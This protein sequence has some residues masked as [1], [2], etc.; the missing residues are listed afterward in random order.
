MATAGS[1]TK[2]S[3][4]MDVEVSTSGGDGVRT[5]ANEIRK[6]GQ[7]GS[8]AG[9]E[10][11]RLASE[12]DAVAA[13]ADSIKAI[14]NLDAELRKAA[15]AAVETAAATEKMN[16]AFQEASSKTLAASEKYA[17]LVAQQSKLRDEN[18]A[19][20]LTLADLKLNT[21]AVVA[22]TSAHQEVVR[23]GKNSINENKKALL[24]LSSTLAESKAELNAAEAAE[25]RLADGL[26]KA[27]KASDAANAALRDRTA[28]LEG[29]QA[30]AGALGVQTDNL[31]VA[32]ERLTA[33]TK[34]LAASAEAQRAA[35]EATAAR[36]A[37]SA[38]IQAKFAEAVK[39]ADKAL[40]D[41]VATLRN[42]DSALAS[43]VA[44]NTEAIS[45]GEKDV[46]LNERR[47]AAARRLL[48][49][50]RLLSAAQRELANSM[51]TARA[52]TVAEAQAQVEAAA[53]AKASL[54]ATQALVT[55][56]RNAGA[57]IQQAFGVIGVRSLNEI[58]TELDQTET[59]LSLL[60]RR[61]KAGAISAGDLERAMGGAKVRMAQLQAEIANVPATPGVFERMS[62]TINHL[63][64]RFGALSAAIATVGI[65]VKPI[66]D[67]EI[68]LQRLN[69][70]LNTVTGS[71]EAT[72]QTIEFL[73]DVSQ[74]S[75]QSFSDLTGSFSKFAASAVNAGVPLSTVQTVFANA[76]RAAGNLGLETEATGRILNALGQIASKGTVQMEELKG[77]L[78]ESLPGAMNL[79]AK[80]LGL[81]TQE[82]TKLIESGGLLA[83]DAL[84]AIGDAMLQLASK[85]GE[86][87]GL[88]A[89][90]N[91]FT[92]VIKEAG[93]TVAEGAFGKAVGDILGGLG[94]SI[95]YVIFGVT[96]IAE[97]FTTTGQKIG[98]VIGALVTRDFKSLSGALDD[99]QKKSDE[100]MAGLAERITG[101]GLA[102]TAAAPKVQQLAS[103]VEASH[104]AVIA[105]SDSFQL[106]TQALVT[107]EKAHG[108]L[109]AANAG[110]VTALD[111]TATSVGA[112]ATL[113]P[114][115]VID[116]QK[117]VDAAVLNTQVTDKLAQAKKFEG[118]ALIAVAALAGN[119]IA[120]Q[121]ARAKAAQDAAAAARDQATADKELVATYEAK[122]VA[123]TK[124]AEAEGGMTEQ[125]KQAIEAIDKLIAKS[126]SEAEKTN[127][128][129]TSLEREAL[130][131]RLATEALDD[132]SSKLGEYQ[133]ALKEAKNAYVALEVEQ[134]RG[135][136]TSDQVAKAAVAVATAEA[137]VKDALDDT[138]AARARAVKAT[139]DHNNIILATLNLQK[140]QLQAEIAMYEAEGNSYKA[141]EA[142]IRL[143]ELEV[144]ILQATIDAKI[145][146]IKA[147]RLQ[148]EADVEAAKA[149][150]TY[151]EAKRAEIEARLAAIKVKELEAEAL[152]SGIGLMQ[153]QIDNLRMY[154]TESVK[155][156]GASA[157]AIGGE[158][159]AINKNTTAWDSN[160]A[161]LVKSA[162]ARKSTS[163][164]ATYDKNGWATNSDG[165]II[166]ARA[167]TPDSVLSS[168]QSAGFSAADAQTIAAQAGLI[169]NGQVVL[170]GE[171][172]GMTLDG[173]IAKAIAKQQAAQ[174]FAGVTN[175]D[176]KIRDFGST[177][178][179]E[180]GGSMVVTPGK[181][182]GGSGSSPFPSPSPAP[183][184]VSPTPA[185]AAVP[186]SV[187]RVIIQNPDG[188]T[189]QVDTASENDAAGLVMML[190][191]LGNAARRS[192]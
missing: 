30:S 5:L 147:T 28:A 190:K 139:Q 149:T 27:A 175:T 116:Y 43:Y 17:A 184:P 121:Q 177:I 37:E 79:T 15:T 6:L 173:A 24:E 54:A 84:P 40:E 64:N 34:D 150:G 125:R 140:A 112:Q 130:S 186:I 9:A 35:M 23:S 29:A 174:S 165:Q 2:R 168:I 154:G 162:D 66:I 70:V 143:K 182:A 185:P 56:A 96:L 159:T 7:D 129:A 153:K 31:V 39:I 65:A 134:R 59:A 145:A 61:F 138:A 51:N 19:T 157:T 48:E 104:T 179:T 180:S 113:W 57:A 25:K 167:N 172:A 114:R 161:A 78:G 103:A 81:T 33:S 107:S 90:W 181:T 111:K 41:Q 1:N 136:A 166:S 98:A 152:R 178:R 92:N 85:S 87:D 100:K 151:T 94:K 123:L 163:N 80:A 89:S 45:T 135:I 131:R 137:R 101:T 122:K 44:A 50:D 148:I 73:R 82:L 142:K 170:Q 62:G 105:S 118:E 83:E 188:T 164:G 77:Q 108:L 36:E 169:R 95:E 93:T 10:F 132:N 26:T 14:A 160:Y 69:R 16:L 109:A 133:A 192:V 119:E 76:A 189:T 71:S 52:A 191:S 141:L 124:L 106:H 13:Q 53:A 155:A 21:D 117:A 8:E 42:A 58:Q 18:K 88:T 115:V 32:Q 110:L 146:E 171:Y 183:A 127:Q 187:H 158:T 74:E 102:A 55:E 144:K 156:Y 91:R 97:S 75:G 63:I 126:S 99:I 46:A 60:E 22:A 128:V 176:L 11:Q 47:I 68:E 3:V 49:E 38:A 120:T 4:Q 86:V 12:L 72:A 20:A 67:A